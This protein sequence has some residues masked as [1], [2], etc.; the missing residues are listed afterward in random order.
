MEAELP[1][2]ARVAIDSLDPP[3]AKLLPPSLTIVVG[4]IMTSSGLCVLCGA[5]PL[6]C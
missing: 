4:L 2:L 6:T 5:L 1:D 3:L